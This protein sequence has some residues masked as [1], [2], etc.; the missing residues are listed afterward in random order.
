MDTKVEHEKETRVAT[1][2]LEVE[3]T[4]FLK[5]NFD[6]K[7]DTLTVD[8]RTFKKVG[9]GTKGKLVDANTGNVVIDNNRKQFGALTTDDNTWFVAKSKELTELY[10]LDGELV[11]EIPTHVIRNVSNMGTNGSES[12]TLTCDGLGKLHLDQT[13]ARKQWAEEK[14]ARRMHDIAA[15]EQDL[16]RDVVV[17]TPAVTAEVEEICEAYVTHNDFEWVLDL[18]NKLE[19]AMA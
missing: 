1:D 19:K 9:I 15:I 10:T 5:H 3:F 7:E 4:G 8:N 18:E 17:E 11:T 12:Y 16:E 2:Q 13:W 14:R 6:W